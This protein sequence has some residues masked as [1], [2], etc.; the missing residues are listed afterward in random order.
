[1]KKVIAVL[2]LML[3]LIVPTFAQTA[4]EIPVTTP[5]NPVE[6]GNG[7]PI[8]L[9]GNRELTEGAPLVLAPTTEQ[10]FAAN[11]DA[12]GLNPPG[13]N[14]VGIAFAGTARNAVFDTVAEFG[15]GC[16]FV[17]PYRLNDQGV[18][19]RIISRCDGNLLVLP[20]FAGAHYF[21]YTFSASAPAAPIGFDLLQQITVEFDS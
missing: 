11:I 10:S 9:F 14:R 3:L 21:F 15:V 8:A 5:I 17:F 19:E 1:M 2:V 6:L 18:L 4:P 13:A 12:L 16:T 7:I 20:M